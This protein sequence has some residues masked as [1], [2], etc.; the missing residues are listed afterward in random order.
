MIDAATLSAVATAKQSAYEIAY[1]ALL[2][3]ADNMP[4]MA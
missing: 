4:A 3:E 2:S 1:S